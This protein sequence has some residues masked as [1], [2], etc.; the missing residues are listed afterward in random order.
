MKRVYNYFPQNDNIGYCPITDTIKVR[1]LA[2]PRSGEAV[3]NQFVICYHSA[4]VKKF[5]SYNTVCLTW[6]GCAR[7]LTIYPEA[8]SYSVTTSK[9][10][11]AFLRDELNLSDSN[12]DELRK[13]AKTES[14][15]RDCPL[16][17]Q[18]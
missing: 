1:N 9:Y 8:F 2:S 17:V 6:D 16:F 18:L 4:L 14:F 3:K 10:S 5:Q 11:R 13:L 15:G 12:I 7:V